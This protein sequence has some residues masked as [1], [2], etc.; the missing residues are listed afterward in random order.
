VNITQNLTSVNRTVTANRKKQ[1]LVVHYFGALGS[2]EQ[3]CAYFKN[4]NRRASAHYFVDD[5]GVYQCV[6]DKYASWHCGDGGTGTY[7]SR[8]NNSNSIGIEVRP[9]KANTATMGAGDKDWYFR[10]A[11]IS[12]LETLVKSLMATHNIDIDHVIRH[13]DVTAKLCPR[14]WVGDDINSY[15]GKSGNKLWAEFK[16]GLT[17]ESDKEMVK[18]NTV[19]EMPEWARATMQKLFDRK[20]VNSF[21]FTEEAL[22]MFV[23]NDRAGLYK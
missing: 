19:A 13:Y 23:I 16:A 18:Y 17:A 15:Y 5:S 8:C 4:V 20:L 12:N 21:G 2:A 22:R 11:T 1:Y 7:K 14:P 3:T 6:E 9:Y 10:E